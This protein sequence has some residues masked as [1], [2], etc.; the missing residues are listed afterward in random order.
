MVREG[1]TKKVAFKQRLEGGISRGE[2]SV[3]PLHSLTLPVSRSRP[4]KMCI[5]SAGGA[6]PA[7][8]GGGMKF[9][10]DHV[11]DT[12]AELDRI[13]S[14]NLKNNVLQ[15]PLCEKTISVNIQRNPKEGLLCASSQASCCHVI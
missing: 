12:T 5:G 15:L 6:A 9:F 10:S 7:Q 1:L 4:W 3:G 11:V 14:R 13:K 2:S 8:A